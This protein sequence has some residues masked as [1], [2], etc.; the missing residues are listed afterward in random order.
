[1]SRREILERNNVTDKSGWE[2]ENCPYCKKEYVW[3]HDPNLKHGGAVL[4]YEKKTIIC[5][6]CGGK[7]TLPKSVEAEYR[8]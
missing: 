3:R 4:G 5:P 2:L 6:D 7:I 1:M 8:W